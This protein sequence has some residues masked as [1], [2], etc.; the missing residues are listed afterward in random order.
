MI[1]ADSIPFTIDGIP[2]AVRIESSLVERPSLLAP[3]VAAAGA[4]LLVVGVIS[5]TSAALQRL[6]VADLCLGW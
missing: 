5:R 3:I 6:M 4:L 2:V 1:V